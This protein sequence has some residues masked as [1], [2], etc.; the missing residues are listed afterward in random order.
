MPSPK[1]GSLR[2]YK[3]ILWDKPRKKDDI[4]GLWLILKGEERMCLCVCMCAC[5]HVSVKIQSQPFH[6]IKT[7]VTTIIIECLILPQRHSRQP[8]AL[9]RQFII[10]CVRMLWNKSKIT[11][12]NSASVNSIVFQFLILISCWSSLLISSL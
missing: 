2:I 9:E 3:S 5:P 11:Q 1:L 10:M 8:P 6:P 7:P 12:R 4:P